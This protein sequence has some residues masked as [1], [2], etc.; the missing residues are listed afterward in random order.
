[1]FGDDL[2]YWAFEEDNFLS[3]LKEYLDLD[4][5]LPKIAKEKSYTVSIIR[6]QCLDEKGTREKS[7]K[8]WS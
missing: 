2:K 4:K 3:K 6:M 1:M 8:F 7:L 5:L